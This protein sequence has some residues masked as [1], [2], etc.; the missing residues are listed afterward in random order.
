MQA[1][2]GG[3]LPGHGEFQT[4]CNRPNISPQSKRYLV[5]TFGQM[6]E[7]AKHKVCNLKTIAIPKSNK[8]PFLNCAYG[9]LISL[10]CICVYLCV[11]MY[12]HVFVPFGQIISQDLHQKINF[13]GKLL[14]KF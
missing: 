14:Q 5:D 8:L 6:H 7:S 2:N 10:L 12:L 3:Q 9:Q 1:V 11:S 4:H 13:P